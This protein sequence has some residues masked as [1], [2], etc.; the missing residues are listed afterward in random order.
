MIH[1][2]LTALLIDALRPAL[3]TCLIILIVQINVTHRASHINQIIP[4]VASVILKAS[5]SCLIILIVQSQR[6]AQFLILVTQ[7]ATIST[8]V[9]N[10]VIILIHVT[11]IV[12]ASIH[13]MKIV[14]TSIHVMK[15]AHVSVEV[16]LSVD[17]NVRYH[18]INVLKSAQTLINVT[19]IAT[20]TLAMMIALAMFLN[21]PKD[22]ITSTVAMRIALK[23][24]RLVVIEP[25]IHVRTTLH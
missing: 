3:I 25:Q 10:S 12:L 8:H 22:V 1:I 17:L 19:K 21:A 7:N 14:P 2:I 15:I 6:Y 16:A 20:R 5:T 13:V 4:I 11:R 24:I 18:L 9:I 23:L